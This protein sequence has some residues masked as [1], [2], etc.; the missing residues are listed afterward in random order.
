M[1]DICRFISWNKM[2]E[3]SLV[4]LCHLK[5]DMQ[6]NLDNTLGKRNNFEFKDNYDVFGV[7]DF[8]RLSR[9]L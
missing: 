6:N 2:T 3:N 4:K 9:H 5:S 7:R 8:S 1:I